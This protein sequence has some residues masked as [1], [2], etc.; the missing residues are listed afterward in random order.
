LMQAVSPDG[1]AWNVESLRERPSLAEARDEPF[2]WASVL[3]TAVL[4]AAVVYL[5]VIDPFSPFL[6]F[7]VLPLLIAWI[8]ER[9][10]SALRPLIR[11]ETSGPPPE[12]VVWK[13]N[14]RF[15]SRKLERTAVQAIE[16]GRP[17]NDLPGLSLVRVES[18]GSGARARDRGRAPAG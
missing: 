17:E 3:V 6:L 14:A 7:G 16:D 2:F 10:T 4:V 5:V 11:A 15:G 9:G 13:S 8:A 18:K 12:V 1:R